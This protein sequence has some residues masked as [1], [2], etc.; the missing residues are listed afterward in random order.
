MRTH[1]SALPDAFRRLSRDGVDHPSDGDLLG[2][3]ASTRSEDA[4]T[5]LLTRHGPMVLGVCRRSLRNAADADDAFQ[6]VFVVLARRAGALVGYGSVAG[7][8]YTTAVRIA[9]KARA[10][11]T[12][13]RVRERKAAQMR[14]TESPVKDDDGDLR[15]V[16]DEEL[17]RLGSRY[18]DP[19][20][21]C[22]LEGKSRDEA[23]RLLG[24]PEGTVNGRLS[25]AKELLRARLARR[26]VAC[27][28]ATLAAVLSAPPVSAVS[29][30]L[31][32]Q[33]LA[34]VGGSV[35]AAVA[36]LSSGLAPAWG[37]GRTVA[38]VSLATTCGLI[39]L[40]LGRP[41]DPRVPHPAQRQ[42]APAAPVRL[43]HGSEVLAVAASLDGRIA[44]VGP[45]ADARV[46]RG[47]GT[48]V[49]RG[50]LTGGGSAVAFAPGGT[51]IAAA[52]YD[53]SVRVWDAVTGVL[54]HT[55]EGHGGAAQ[56]VVF[57]PDGSL[58]ATAGEDGR[59]RLWDGAT[60]KFLRDLEG[61]DGRVWGLSFSP[62]GQ[63][64]ASAGG[65]KTVRLWNPTTGVERRRFS[66]LKGGVYAVAFH[67]SGQKLAV[68]ADNTV[69]LLDADT[70]REVGR[71]MTS[72]TAVTWFTF[73]PDGRTL[74]YRD[75]KTVRLW[76]VAAG[77]ERLA[78]EL[79]AEP[80]A[81]AFRQDGRG[82]VAATG[83]G[84]DVL[85]LRRH[86]RPIPGADANALF[87]QLAGADAA[88]AGR[89]IEALASDAASAVPLLRERLHAVPDL[90]ARI[91]ALVGRLGDREFAD[92]ERASK[93]LAE[94]GA[95]AGPAL[96]HALA[97]V[98]AP[99]VRQRAERLLA[100]F[101]SS[102]P[103]EPTATEVRAVEVLERAGTPEAREVLTILAD[104]PLDTPLKREAAVALA[105]L[106]AGRR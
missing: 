5:A 90:A 3:F 4:F 60:G 23:A 82:L 2:T 83:D 32:G 13:R 84:A 22:C 80:A 57:S 61:H 44:T 41:T 30:E 14:P 75:G 1:R 31:A 101:T 24:W 73:A 21:L 89:A 34:A 28:V 47:D 91:D 97:T 74:A 18:R 64:L 33:T 8:L 104:R 95:E 17:D 12:R 96:R 27:S 85:D 81:L 39:G 88:L 35:P 48:A 86:T 67:S 29:V 79:S 19:V 15:A 25:R 49:A 6:A 71:V 68:A 106:K 50:S 36:A 103:R 105:R 78:V 99:E 10:K 20:V 16:L 100:R 53:G 59:V 37:V 72:R 11:D 45:G 38:V 58:L 102:A 40:S 69:L 52:G 66:G 76:E 62:A 26:G 9:L 70:G 92:R 42:S 65:D 43:A 7:W 63:L 54:R 46:W 94:I 56:A 51:T 55:L 98:S 87:A 93:E 77:A